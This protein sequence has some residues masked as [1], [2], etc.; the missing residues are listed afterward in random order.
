MSCIKSV[1]S[2][3]IGIAV[4]MG[5]ISSVHKLILNYLP[6]HQQF[7]NSG[8]EEITIEHLLTMTSGLEWDEC[9]TGHGTSEKDID[10]IYFECQDDP[11]ACVLENPLVNQPG[12][13]FTYN[14]EGRIIQG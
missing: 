12:E 7:K 4:D 13:K 14:G 1:T 5:Y 2:A 6:D 11:V 9:S 3:C 10:K 8:K